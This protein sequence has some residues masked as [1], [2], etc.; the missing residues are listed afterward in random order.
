[1]KCLQ[2]SRVFNMSHIAQPAPAKRPLNCKLHE[3]SRKRVR[4]NEKEQEWSTTLI[5]AGHGADL[6]EAVYNKLY[7]HVRDT[8]RA[9]VYYFRVCAK[10]WSHPKLKVALIMNSVAGEEATRAQAQG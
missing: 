4:R 3:W 8:I 2:Q 10:V 6:T 1:M 7:N 9:A 5:S